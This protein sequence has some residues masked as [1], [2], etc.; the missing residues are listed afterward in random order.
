MIYLFDV[1]VAPSETS[2]NFKT[3][4]Q[5]KK[6]KSK[7]LPFPFHVSLTSIKQ[8]HSAGHYQSKVYFLTSQYI[9]RFA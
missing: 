2:I 1:L 7:P 3:S 8:Y 5:T 9:K 4:K 6:K